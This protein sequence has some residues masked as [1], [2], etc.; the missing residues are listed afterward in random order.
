MTSWDDQDKLERTSGCEGLRGLRQ[1]DLLAPGQGDRAGRGHGATRVAGGLHSHAS[2]VRATLPGRSGHRES[3][4]RSRSLDDRRDQRRWGDRQNR[5][6]RWWWRWWWRR[7]WWWWRWWWRVRDSDRAVHLARVNP[8]LIVEG[9]D[10]GERVCEREADREDWLCLDAGVGVPL[11][12]LRRE[13]LDDV[14]DVIWRSGGT[15][16]EPGDGFAEVDRCVAGVGAEGPVV[17]DVDRLIRG[18]GSGRDR[19]PGDEGDET[20][21]GVTTTACQLRIPSRRISSR[22]VGPRTGD[23]CSP[24]GWFTA[25]EGMVSPATKGWFHP[26]LSVG[27]ASGAVRSHAEADTRGTPPQACASIPLHVRPQRRQSR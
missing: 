20:D 9:P 2:R 23:V 13:R 3:C 18:D 7:R 22:K 19:G 11:F 4:D 27:F 6:W 5:W 25:N 8:A 24:K 16:P 15:D 10:V 17:A 14:P 26:Q 12:D 21:K 1:G